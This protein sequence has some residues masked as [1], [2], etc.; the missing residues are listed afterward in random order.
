MTTKKKE[1]NEGGKIGVTITAQFILE[2]GVSIADI[3]ECVESALENLRGQGEATAV[4]YIPS[5][6]VEIK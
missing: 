5:C 3:T 4:M 6:R 1:P 2:P